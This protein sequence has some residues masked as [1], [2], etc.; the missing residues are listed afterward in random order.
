MVAANSVAQ[1]PAHVIVVEPDS[2]RSELFDLL[3]QRLDAQVLPAH[4][5]LD[6]VEMAGTCTGLRVAVIC[7]SAKTS[8]CRELVANLRAMHP[9]LGVILISNEASSDAFREAVA[10]EVDEFVAEPTS[11][12]YIEEIVAEMISAQDLHWS[13]IP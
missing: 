4:S 13:A 7:W 3:S 12:D 10:A 1:E 11:P 8:G 9:D 2:R 5:A 6:A